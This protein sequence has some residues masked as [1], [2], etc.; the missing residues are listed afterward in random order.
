MILCLIH[1]I[2]CFFH[3]IKE[4]ETYL[5]ILSILLINIVVK[6]IK[7]HKDDVK[8]SKDLTIEEQLNEDADKIATTRVKLPLNIHF[9]S[10]PFAIYIRGIYT[11]PS[12]QNNSRS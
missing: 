3:K 2:N 7:G 12:A 10:A 8:L 9:P 4:S 5:A 11:P 1:I 6:H